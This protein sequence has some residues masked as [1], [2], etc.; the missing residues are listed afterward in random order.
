MLLTVEAATRDIDAVRH[1][2]ARH[3][4][5]HTTQREA[6]AH[7]HTRTKRDGATAEAEAGK[8]KRQLALAHCPLR[9]DRS[10]QVWLFFV[11][12]AVWKLHFPPANLE[13]AGVA[14]RYRP[15]GPQ[16]PP[17][18]PSATQLSWQPARETGKAVAQRATGRDPT[19]RTSHTSAQPQADAVGRDGNGHAKVRRRKRQE[20]NVQ[21]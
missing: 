9:R 18:F 7:T 4:R 13:G 6:R 20:I 2:A 3:R 19:P 1:S 15:G 17:S 8:V 12:P 21:L 10:A 5:T 16:R 14:I 11:Y